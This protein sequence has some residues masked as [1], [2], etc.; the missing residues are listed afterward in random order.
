MPTREPVAIAGRQLQHR[1]QRPALSQRQRAAEPQVAEAG[2]VLHEVDARDAVAHIA[3]AVAVLREFRA[4]GIG[5]AESAVPTLD[6]GVHHAAAGDE[7]GDLHRPLCGATE[8]RCETGAVAH[9]VAL[10]LGV[11]EEGF[12]RRAAGDE[13]VGPVETDAVD[14]LAGRHHRALPERRQRREARERGLVEGLE[15][16]RL[17]ERGDHEA[18]N[19]DETCE[20][21]SPAPMPTVTDHRR[22]SAAA[23]LAIG[24]P[25]VA[26]L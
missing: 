5:Q 18:E 9:R 23:L 3:D 14:R 13:L 21:H 4:V 2:L 22:L 19:R 8:D 25:P 10:A 12:A 15:A 7:H 17:C 16:L 6:A 1:P 20:T 24:H 26:P 11:E